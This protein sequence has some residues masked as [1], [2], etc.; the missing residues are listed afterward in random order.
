MPK[1]TDL[2]TVKAVLTRN[3]LDV[4]T[5]AAILEDLNREIEQ[6]DDEPKPPPVKK[7]F[8][9]LV[10]DP[11]GILDDAPDLVGWV[12]Q[13][14]EEESP[15]TVPDRLGKAAALYNATPKGRRLPVQTVAEACEFIPARL[16]KEAEAWVKTK[17]PVLVVPTGK[18]V[19]AM[20]SVF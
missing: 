5:V 2:D 12:V 19:K 6:E 16:H 13:V 8:A 9:I 11:E 20:P 7:Q 3:A 14:P 10:S 1:K 18:A 15:L 4:R 17:E